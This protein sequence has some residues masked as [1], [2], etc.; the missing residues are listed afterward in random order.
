MLGLVTESGGLIVCE[1]RGVWDVVDM[2]VIVEAQEGGVGARGN[3][4]E[5]QRQGGC[6]STLS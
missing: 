1:C 5:E 3:A 2:L 4:G 6:M